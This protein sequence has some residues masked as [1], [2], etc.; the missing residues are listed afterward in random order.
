M[1]TTPAWKYHRAFPFCV[2]TVDISALNPDD[3]DTGTF[4]IRGLTFEDAMKLYWLTESIDISWEI[5]TTVVNDGGGNVDASQSVSLT[6]DGST[7]SG[8]YI[9]VPNERVCFD[10]P[11]DSDWLYHNQTILDA[12][13]ID[14]VNYDVVTL[15]AAAAASGM[16][17]WPI[18]NS[19]F[20]DENGDYCLTFQVA[21]GDSSTLFIGSGGKVGAWANNLG[22]QD[23]AVLSGSVRVHGIVTG[24]G[25]SYVSGGSLSS[26][27]IT[28]NFYTVA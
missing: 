22:Y 25:L 23:V 4:V 18:E 15:F 9:A 2:E 10:Q 19:V 3:Q 17:V 26:I 8:S 13:T 6:A 12:E 28:P 7:G 5:G 20:I 24:N 1:S 21:P 11:T 27:S 14:G 16:S